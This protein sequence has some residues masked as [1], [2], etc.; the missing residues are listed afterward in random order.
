MQLHSVVALRY[1]WNLALKVGDPQDKIDG[2]WTKLIDEEGR[3]LD[4][5]S[6]GRNE[7]HYH[8]YQHVKCQIGF[9]RKCIDGEN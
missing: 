8:H 7:H 9:V 4:R 5:L 6:L 2:A 1:G 3:E